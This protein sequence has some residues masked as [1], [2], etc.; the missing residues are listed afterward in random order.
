MMDHVFHFLFLTDHRMMGVRYKISSLY[1]LLQ[2]FRVISFRPWSKLTESCIHNIFVV[3]VILL[4]TLI[5]TTHLIESSD[6]LV[7][8]FLHNW[9]ICSFWSLVF[10]IHVAKVRKIYV[11]LTN[12]S[13]KFGSIKSCPC[14]HTTKFT[15]WALFWAE[16][17]TKSLVTYPFSK[18]R[19]LM[20]G[21]NLENF[22]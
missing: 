17:S 12:G 16:N 4:L 18:M 5:R 14:L 20:I 7:L 13:Q 6:I 10:K 3:E 9:E 19:T 11:H 21:P 2:S 15:C 22:S 8:H 1:L